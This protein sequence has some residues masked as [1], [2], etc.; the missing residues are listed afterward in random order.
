M[1]GTNA[2]DLGYARRRYRPLFELGRGGMAKVYL[3]ESL[4]SGVRKLVVLKVL[5]RELA[6]DEEV[7][8]AF[9]REAELS[10]RMN[11]P[12]VVQVFEVVEYSGVPVIVME[13]LDGVSLSRV[14]QHLQ[15]GGQAMPERLHLYVLTQ[16]LAGLHHFHELRDFEGNSLNAVHRDVSPQ[17]VLVLHEGPVK[18]VD[19]GIAKVNAAT[20]H[21]TRTGMVKGKIHYMPPEQLL[22]ESG[23]DRRADIFAVG[24]ML[25]EAIAG[26]R[27]WAGYAEGKVVR[28]LARGELPR[29]RDAV[30]EVSE[31]LERI[32]EKALA[33]DVAQRYE[34][35]QEMQFELERALEA[36]KQHVNPRELLEFMNR[37]FGEH[38]LF[39]RRAVERAL[40]DP[41][42][43]ISAVMECVTPA[44]REY[45]ALALGS[46]SGHHRI[47]HGSAVL[48]S[49]SH[50][51]EIAADSSSQFEVKG[52]GDLSSRSQMAIDLGLGTQSSPGSELSVRS[53]S[54]TRSWKMAAVLL[55]IGVGSAGVWY[56]FRNDAQRANTPA[57]SPPAARLVQVRIEAQPPGA[58]ISLN[59]QAL[60]TSPYQGKLPAS[61][62]EQVV[63]VRADGHVTERRSLTLSDDVALSIALQPEPPATPAPAVDPQPSAAAETH[64]ASRG[65]A[66][67]RPRTVGRAAAA[68]PAPAPAPAAAPAAPAPTQD[69]N[70][71][72]PYKLSAD[73]VKIYKPECF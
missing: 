44:V 8:A 54:G 37:H 5:N 65:T 23:I 7:R 42:A 32:V 9:R 70:C 58:R 16:V 11:H 31:N 60:G 39:Q 26:R 24:V 15:Q 41:G 48:E 50:A 18:V 27:M 10:A 43:T 68:A 52:E 56:K 1:N 72:P 36:E 49:G 62:T 51:V 21:H 67:G 13:Y 69:A 25:W 40:R 4:A 73:G 12:N 38:R 30:P 14:L 28:S 19:F 34:S 63:E 47:E 55:L 46:E 71:S 64:P 2:E 66:R 61:S 33:L 17:N 53:R 22:G 45:S 57:V 6:V 20:D 29:L 59:G 3:A 35:A